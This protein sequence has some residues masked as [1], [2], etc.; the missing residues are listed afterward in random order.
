[1]AY[2]TLLDIAKRSGNDSTVGLVESATQENGLLMKLPFKE[3]IGDSYKVKK[4]T[5]LP[6]AVRRMYNAGTA[7]TKSLIT[8]YIYSAHLYSDRSIVDVD[9]ADAAPEGAQALRQEEDLAH[10]AAMANLYN[11]DIY[12]GNNSSDQTQPD[13]IAT[14]LS[15]T[16]FATV[17]AGTGASGSSTSIYLVSFR[18]VMTPRGKV[19]AC[20]GVVSRG[21]SFSA[22]DMGKCY[23]PDDGGTNELLWYTTEFKAKLGFSVYDVRSIGRY[24][25]LTSAIAPTAAGLDSII[26]EMLPFQPDAIFANKVGLKLLKGLKTTITYTP[27][28]RELKLSPASYDGIPIF[29]DENIL[30]TE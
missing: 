9:L 27:A 13:G 17:T 25:G 5:G 8:D 2:L 24:M 11:T 12:Y 30:N 20:E 22:D 21:L 29:L 19:K 1:M 26:T 15:S 23:F 7:P 3:I 18:D 16:A 28:D 10:L 4:R 14:I 6:T